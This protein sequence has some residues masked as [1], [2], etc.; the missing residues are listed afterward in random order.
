MFVSGSSF[1]SA[2]SRNAWLPVK[3]PNPLKPPDAVLAADKVQVVDLP[4]LLAC[5]VRLAANLVQLVYP[6]LKLH[7]QQRLVDPRILAFHVGRINVELLWQ[8]KLLACLLLVPLM[9]EGLPQD[10]G[11]TFD[12]GFHRLNVPAGRA[13][14]LDAFLVLLRHKLLPDRCIEVIHHDT[15]VIVANVLRL[16]GA[17]VQD[18]PVN[19]PLDQKLDVI[20]TFGQRLSHSRIFGRL[21]LQEV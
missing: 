7:V 3:L 9:L 17:L 1:G 10:L 12:P 2:A 16:Q 4:H 14:S 21:L 13:L 8:V 15:V 5:K 19:H 6:V 18:A 11:S 20:L